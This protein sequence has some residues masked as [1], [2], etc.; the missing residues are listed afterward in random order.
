MVLYQKLSLCL[1]VRKLSTLVNKYIE[2][3]SVDVDFIIQIN[4]SDKVFNLFKKSI[5]KFAILL[6][7]VKLEELP[8]DQLEDMGEIYSK[9]DENEKQ[10]F[11]YMKCNLSIIDAMNKNGETIE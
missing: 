10:Y 8:N 4:I 7:F 1:E 9:C 11:N 6:S 2:D 3:Q 5:R